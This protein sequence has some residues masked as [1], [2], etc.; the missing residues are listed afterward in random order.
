MTNHGAKSLVRPALQLVQKLRAEVLYALERAQEAYLKNRA[1]L[2]RFCPM[3][4]LFGNV[5]SKG[6]AI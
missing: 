5:L 2:P 1:H 3:V 6:D 4:S